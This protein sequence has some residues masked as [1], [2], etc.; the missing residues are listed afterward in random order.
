MLPGL[1]DMHAHLKQVE[2]G[3]AYIAAGITTVR[4]MANEFVF[5]NALKESVDKGTGI[6][7]T[8]LRAGIIDGPGPLSNGIMIAE[9]PEQAIALVKKYKAAGFDQIK[10]YSSLSPAIVKVICEEAHREGLSVTGHIPRNMTTMQT[11]DLGLDQ[12]AHLPYVYPDLETDTLTYAFDLTTPANR[13]IVKDLLDKKIVIDPTIA[14]FEFLYRDLQAPITDIEPAF[15][16]LPPSIR[17]EY[18]T[19]GLSPEKARK[20]KA[21]FAAHQR[22]LL[23]LYRAGVPIVAGTDMLLPGFTLYREIELYVAA[24]LTPLEALQAAT[25]VPARVMGR[26][27][28]SGTLETGKQADIILVDGDPLHNIRDIRKVTKV[29]KGGQLYDSGEIH[30]LAGFEEGNKAL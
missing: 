30:R 4:D 6:G 1:W 7:P 8:I 28:V 13:R 14:L 19:T 20:R 12:V 23:Q 10:L 29:I 18:I 3:P 16:S 5:I 11:I 26:L 24:G 21:W 9:T 22:L 15:Y 27:S 2:W 17:K 25:L